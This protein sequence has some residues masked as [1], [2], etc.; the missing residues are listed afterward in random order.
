[1]EF[2]RRTVVITAPSQVCLP[3]G[4]YLDKWETDLL[5]WLGESWITGLT[6]IQ[7][8]AI[9][10]VLFNLGEEIFQLNAHPDGKQTCEGAAMILLTTPEDLS[11]TCRDR[12]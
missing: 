11:P 12:A 7:L 4:P 9:Y 10:S 5:E 6:D 3:S 8:E 2:M 1:M